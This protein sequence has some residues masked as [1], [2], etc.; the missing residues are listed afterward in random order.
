M[1]L[2]DRDPR[3]DIGQTGGR[4]E[5]GPW[6]KPRLSMR[7]QLQNKFVLS[8]MGTDVATNL[9][10]ILS[11]NSLCVMPRPTVESWFLESWLRPGVHYAEVADDFSDLPQVLDH[12]LA[13][14]EEAEAIVRNA[15]AHARMFMDPAVER[16]V[17]LLVLQR[18]F[19]LARVGP[20]TDPLTL[21]ESRDLEGAALS[22]FHA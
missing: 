8:V 11:S 5:H 20:E 7:R 12:Y 6:C 3:F 17:G 22:E 21:D 10:W 4:H 14:S 9:K 13:H 18:W 19:D 1:R 16:L 15:R 2:H